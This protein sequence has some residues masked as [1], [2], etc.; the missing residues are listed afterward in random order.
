MF[1]HWFG[2]KATNTSSLLFAIQS[3]EP[4]K[5]AWEAL[6]YIPIVLVIVILATLVVTALRLTNAVRMDVIPVNAVLAALG[7]VSTLLILFRIIAPPVFAV[8]RTIT[9]EGTIQVPIFFALLTAMGIAFGSVLAMREAGL[10]VSDLRAL[11]DDEA[12]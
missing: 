3:T 10:S 12:S 11:P 8:E 1:F 6:A 7:L 2:V 4:G 9:Y 5:N